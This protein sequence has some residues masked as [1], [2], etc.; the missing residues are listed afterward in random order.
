[1]KKSGV[2][3]AL[4]RRIFAAGSYRCAGCGLQGREERFAKGGYGYPTDLPAVFLSIDH[5]IPRA[6]G[7]SSEPANLRALCTTCNTQK[8]VRAA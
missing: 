4:R 3:G 7:G 2:S 5:V 8:G 1:M 6:K